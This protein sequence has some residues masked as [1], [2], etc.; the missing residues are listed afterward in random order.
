MNVTL[1]I[2]PINLED[3]HFTPWTE[4]GLNG[5]FSLELMSN[6]WEFLLPD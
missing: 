2:Q 5:K 4:Q 6:E 3:A 1:L